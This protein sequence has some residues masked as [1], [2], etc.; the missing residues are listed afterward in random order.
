MW[1]RRLCLL[2]LFSFFFT[3]SSLAVY[4]DSLLVARSVRSGKVVVLKPQRK[5]TF[6]LN[7]GQVIKGKYRVVDS[8]TVIVANKRDTATVLLSN[9]EH[10]TSP[11]TVARIFGVLLSGTGLYGILLGQAFMVAAG[12]MNIS[13]LG[14][15]LVSGI[16]YGL[17]LVLLIAGALLLILGTGLFFAGRK[18]KAKKWKFLI[19]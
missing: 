11:S 4:R 3:L 10:I 13:N 9:I 8:Q 14:A 5:Y 1:A 7:N 19:K 17:G 2:L 15:V 6:K 12:S 16:I 18:F